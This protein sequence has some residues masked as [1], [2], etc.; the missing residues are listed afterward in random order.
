M[1]TKNAVKVYVPESY[2]HV[3]NR[4]VDKQPIFHDDSDK[5]YL[6]SLFKKYLSP[7]VIKRKGHTAFASY[8][9]IIDLL[10]YCLM[11]NHFHLLFYQHADLE[12]LVGLMRRIMTSY[13]MYFNKKYDR[14]G[15]LFQ[16]R[17]LASRID[18]DPYLHHVSRYI[19]RNPKF[20]SEYQ[21]SSLRYYTSDAHA[22]WVKPK[23]IL[24]LFNN[25]P[26][27]YFDFLASMDEDDKEALA[28]IM[29]HP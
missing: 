28:S 1:P 14:V 11:D 2:Y 3:Y 5:A 22:D 4:G 6:L 29:A 16:G 18:N 10:A 9:G 13:S 21:F 20:W 12:A 25:N 17:Y 24:S 19:H 15:P 8:S 26:L 23:A 27:Q 7:V